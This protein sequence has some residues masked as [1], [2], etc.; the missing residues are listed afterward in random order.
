MSK[1][2]ANSPPQGEIIIYPT[3]DGNTRIEVWFVDE[4]VYQI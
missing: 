1:P 4:T 3:E 2:D